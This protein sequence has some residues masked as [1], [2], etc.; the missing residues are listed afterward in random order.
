MH[1]IKRDA[2]IASILV[3][4][5]LLCCIIMY[6]WG[7]EINS[8]IVIVPLMAAWGASALIG[9]VFIIRTLRQLMHQ[10][11]HRHE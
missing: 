5:F 10:G 8:K 1:T 9:P 4:V 3:I 7:H 11:V 6:E 2:S